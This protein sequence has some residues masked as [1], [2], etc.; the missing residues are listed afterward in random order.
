LLLAAPASHPDILMTSSDRRAD[1]ARCAALCCV[2]LAF[3]RS[4]LFAFDKPAGEPCANLGPKGRCRI[5]ADRAAMGFAGCQAYD[6]LGAGQAVTQDLFGGANWQNDEALLGP[7]ME[8]FAVMRRAHE[9]LDL[10]IRARALPL[11]QTALERLDAAQRA[12]DPEAGWTRADVSSGRIA[13][14]TEA[15][16]GVLRS[17]APLVGAR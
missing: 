10:L 2:A 6:C 9:T 13:R 11:P 7:M 8:A 14:E 5:H 3:D 1:C 15:A 4:S 16:E 17:L 12:L